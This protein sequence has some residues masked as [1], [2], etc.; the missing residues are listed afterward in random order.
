MQKHL[1]RTLLAGACIIG[2]SW[3]AAGSAL[4][5]T[6]PC[7]F[8]NKI[9]SSVPTAPGNIDT[10]MNTMQVVGYWTGHDI[11][12]SGDGVHG[13]MVSGTIDSATCNSPQQVIAAANYD[14]NCSFIQHLPHWS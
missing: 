4:A 9:Y 3:C 10:Q 13:T 8:P 2:S 12:L 1:Q 7:W 11:V 14:G 6:V 5:N